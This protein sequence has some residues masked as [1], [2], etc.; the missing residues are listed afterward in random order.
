MNEKCKNV[1]V[2]LLTAAFLLSFLVWSLVK[3]DEQRSLSERRA[4]AQFPALTADSVLSGK[5]MTEFESYTLDQFPLRERFRTLKAVT[6][7]DVFRQRDN[8]GLYSDRGYL[9]KLDFPL[10]EASVRNASERFGYVYERYL[11]GKNV[12]FA[13]VPDKNYY[14]SSQYPKLDYAALSAQLDMPYA[15]FIDLTQTLTLESYYR[16]D[17]HWDQEALLPAARTILEAM[18]GEQRD[19]YR[20]IRLDA[21]FYGAYYGQSALPVQPDALCYL[22]SDALEECRVYDYETDQWGSVYDPERAEGDD[23]YELFLGGSKSLLRIENPNAATDRGLLV[24]RDSYGSS[25]VP[26]LAEGYAEI[27]VVDIRYLQP[28]RLG[29][30]LDF[31]EQDVLF[32]Y[33]TTVLNSSNALK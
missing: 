27:T 7:L 17:P 33:S 18:G 5:F 29:G 3:P 32:L 1:L 10:D 6:A 14:T 21:P 19:S 31:S 30:L 20:P 9:A 25:L 13:V 2:V 11:Q 4:L 15:Q 8:N 22:T 23:P 12:Y 26:L 28:E 24:F 16:T